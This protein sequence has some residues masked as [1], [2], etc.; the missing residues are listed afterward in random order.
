MASGGGAI[1]VFVVHAGTRRQKKKKGMGSG[2]AI[3]RRAAHLLAFFFFFF[4]EK[5]RSPAL[6]SPME[7]LIVSHMKDYVP[8]H[9]KYA[10]VNKG[11]ALKGLQPW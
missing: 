5:P 6:P 1:G 2:R 10:P 4:P 7:D 3:Q 9:L 8:P 11:P